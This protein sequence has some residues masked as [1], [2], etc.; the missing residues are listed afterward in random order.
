MIRLH[1]KGGKFHQVLAHHNAQEYLHLYIEAAGIAPDSKGPLFRTTQGAS[2]ILTT[3]AMTRRDVHRM[4][5]R[6]AADAGVSAQ[7]G[8][9]T[10][11][12]TGITTI[13]EMAAPWSTRKNWPAMSPPAPPVST[14]GARRRS[15][16]MR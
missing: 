14:I 1:E 3:N 15:A 16:S 9:H 5:K 4:I 7:I 12:A 13:S 2:R 8:C 11:R 10:F 6:R